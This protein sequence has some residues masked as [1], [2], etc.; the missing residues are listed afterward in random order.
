MKYISIKQ[1]IN[2][3]KYFNRMQ[4][5]NH[6]NQ[7]IKKHSLYTLPIQ[8]PVFFFNKNNFIYSFSSK[9]CPY[10]CQFPNRMD[11]KWNGIKSNV[12]KYNIASFC[13]LK[14][15]WCIILTWVI[16]WNRTIV[17]RQQW[18]IL[19]IKLKKKVFRY[20]CLLCRFSILNVLFTGY[21]VGWMRKD[22]FYIN[23]M[24]INPNSIIVK[25]LLPTMN[26]YNKKLKEKKFP[27]CNQ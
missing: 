18:C 15:R 19:K 1:A 16:R 22:F 27:V 24:L 5:K 9:Q 11:C 23:I 21:F 6:V 4:N 7:Y 3:L 2:K 8:T 20:F 10:I 14:Q 26:T 17:I 25:K 12:G 13:G